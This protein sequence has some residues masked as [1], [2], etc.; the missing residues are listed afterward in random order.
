MLFRRIEHRL[1]HDSDH[2]AVS[3]MV[4][5]AESIVLYFILYMYTCQNKDFLPSFLQRR[6]HEGRIQEGRFW[7]H[8]VASRS[9]C[10]RTIW[11]HM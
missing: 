3:V 6:I 11:R 7:W 2:M 10:Y 9:D 1:H 4:S 5:K 8:L